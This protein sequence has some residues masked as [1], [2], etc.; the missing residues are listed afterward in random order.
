MQNAGVLIRACSLYVEMALNTTSSNYVIFLFCFS[1]GR[2]TDD[3]YDV[4]DI[5]SGGTLN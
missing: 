2:F 3:G 5:T 4:R 1:F